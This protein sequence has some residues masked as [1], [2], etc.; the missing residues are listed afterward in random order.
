MKRVYFH[1]P[2]N[3]SQ[4]L[5]G[6]VVATHGSSY[7][8]L[9][10]GRLYKDVSLGAIVSTP[11]TQRSNFAVQDTVEI[12]ETKTVKS[13][14]VKEITRTTEEGNNETRSS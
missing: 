11:P 8:I 13:K 6:T 3:T 1:D 5:F 2:Q 9:S 10:N 14:K 4:I 7:D 12:S